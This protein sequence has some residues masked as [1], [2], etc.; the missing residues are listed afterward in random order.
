MST[1][2]LL[3]RAAAIDPRI[4]DLIA[5]A[6]SEMWKRTDGPHCVYA[7]ARPYLASLVGWRRGTDPIA[8]PRDINSATRFQR[9]I[10]RRAR[11]TSV[12]EEAFL[13]REDLYATAVL[14]LSD[15]LVERDYRG[16]QEMSE[17]DW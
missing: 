2:T 16:Q 5:A 11:P 10:D 15:A 6:V 12:E 8:N 3:D 13:R 7:D 17:V 9:V 4:T 1:L 14:F